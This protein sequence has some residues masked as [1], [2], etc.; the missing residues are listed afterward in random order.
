MVGALVIV[1]PF[2][3]NGD[4]YCKHCL[5]SDHQTQRV[6]PSD[7][8]TVCDLPDLERAGDAAH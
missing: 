2:L 1:L 8:R 6:E 4:T 5:A 3:F 7:G